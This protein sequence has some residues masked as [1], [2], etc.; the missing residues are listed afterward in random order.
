MP[1]VNPPLVVTEMQMRALAL[2]D[3]VV[4]SNLKVIFSSN[5]PYQSRLQALHALCEAYLQ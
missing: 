5:R 4:R 1:V 3:P 2:A